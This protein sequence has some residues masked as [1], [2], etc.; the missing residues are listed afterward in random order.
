MRAYDIIF[1]KRDGKKLT[2]EEI[3]FLISGYVSGTIPD[4]GSIIPITEKI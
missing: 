1:K 4:Y 3:E 2:R